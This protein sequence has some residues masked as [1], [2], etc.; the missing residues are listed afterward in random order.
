MAL[1]DSSAAG[2]WLTLSLAEQL[3]NIGSDFDRAL[4]WKEKNQTALYS[5]ATTRMLE[6]L[7]LTLSDKRWHDHRL[8]ELVRV[9]EEVCREL[10]S[11]VFNT[12]SANGL[13]KYF[14]VMA[15]NARRHI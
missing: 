6:L 4:K 13:K 15:V 14:Y 10:F 12:A 11:P 2:K 9:R 8:K 3:G 1:H 5:S 7:D